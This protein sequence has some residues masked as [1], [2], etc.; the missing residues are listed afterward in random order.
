MP[1][2]P[3][4]VSVERVVPIKREQLALLQRESGGT[5]VDCSTEVEVSKVIEPEKSDTVVKFLMKRRILMETV[6]FKKKVK[7]IRKSMGGP[8]VT[9]KKRICQS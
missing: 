2:M 7:R 1:A 9:R 5:G 6:P 3:C 4:T 8:G